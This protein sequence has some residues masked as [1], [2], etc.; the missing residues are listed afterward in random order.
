MW[1]NAMDTL[2]KRRAITFLKNLHR[3]KLGP[4]R[5]P[6]M[7]HVKT[8]SGCRDCLM[9][10]PLIKKREILLNATEVAAGISVAQAEELRAVHPIHYFYPN[11]DEIRLSNGDLDPDVYFYLKNVD[12]YDG[13]GF[14]DQQIWDYFNINKSEA[15]KFK[16][17]LFDGIKEPK[18]DYINGQG[19]KAINKYKE[20]HGGHFATKI[21][22]HSK[23]NK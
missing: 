1:S 7:Q 22:Y 15:Q 13:R 16:S 9:Y 6:L 2:Y 18:E 19:L 12:G 11:G 3:I 5:E 10:R 20:Q 8:C 14:T 21:K 23:S 17:K 4:S